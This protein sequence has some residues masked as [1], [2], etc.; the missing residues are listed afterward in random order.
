LE[1]SEAKFIAPMECLPVPQLPEGP[2][3]IYEIKLDGFRAIG[4]KPASA[5]GY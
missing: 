3:W 2:N 5:R 1:K 4:V